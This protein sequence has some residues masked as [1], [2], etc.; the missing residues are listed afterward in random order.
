MISRRLIL[1][2]EAFFAVS[3]IL[4]FLFTGMNFG[5]RQSG[6]L[7]SRTNIVILDQDDYGFVSQGYVY[8]VLA[9][10]PYKK[11][12]T[13]LSE[14][15]LLKIQKALSANRYIDQVYVYRSYDG[16][17]NIYI[18]QFT[19][20]LKLQNSYGTCFLADRKGKV[21][22]LNNSI[23]KH[24]PL[25]TYETDDYNFEKFYKKS[26]ENEVENSEILDN[27]FIFADWVERDNF[28]GNLI[29]QININRH[30]D[31]EL[32]PRMGSRL[33]V[34]CDIVD[35]A[36]FDIYSNKLVKFYE[37]MSDKYLLNNY[38]TINLKYNNQV[39]VTKK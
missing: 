20:V 17:L 23:H 21:L 5:K 28:L 33:V 37:M 16:A 13:K 25:I 18:K 7:W 22:P 34:F 31:I 27:L 35:V 4:L 30:G 12:K 8:D 11:D 36:T 32:I 1:F 29:V 39:V 26:S 38:Q 15:N 24:L 14:I 2:F 10:Y 6:L 19:P 3:V 9:K